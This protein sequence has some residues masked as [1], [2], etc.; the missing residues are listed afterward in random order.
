MP[1]V[2]VTKEEMLAAVAAIEAR[3][4]KVT[5]VRLRAELGDTASFGT[6]G[7]F[8]RALRE[9][10]AEIASQEV[11]PEVP[12]VVQASFQKAWSVASASAQAE[13]A[14]LREALARDSARVKESLGQEYAEHNET[15]LVLELQMADLKSQLTDTSAREMAAHIRVAEL[16][17]ELG[18]LR[19][20]I[21]STESEAQRLLGE[22]LAR[23]S[24]LEVRLDEALKLVE[25]A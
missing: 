8:L 5:Q 10:R 9:S 20:K 2:G 16:S 19:A 24:D 7:P 12:T 4:E 15:I 14:S 21:E 25:S 18:Y 13:L 22:K 1:R 3:G 17:E 6:I 23:I 11:L